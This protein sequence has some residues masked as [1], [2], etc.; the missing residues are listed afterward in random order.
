[1]L[2]Q[3]WDDAVVRIRTIGPATTS[4]GKLT[5]FSFEPIQSDGT[6]GLQPTHY[7]VTYSSDQGYVRSTL[8]AC[9]S[10]SC[11]PA[12]MQICW[13]RWGLGPLTS[14]TITPMKGALTDPCWALCT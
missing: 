7:V 12:A 10:V 5:E 1:M 4:G 6:I 8:V 14:L 9:A 11:V 2:G 3:A 13:H